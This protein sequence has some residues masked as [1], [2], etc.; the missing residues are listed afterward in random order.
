M[1]LLVDPN[2]VGNLPEGPVPKSLMILDWGKL[3][4][5]GNLIFFWI[6]RNGYNSY[7]STQRLPDYSYRVSR[8]APAPLLWRSISGYRV[9]IFID[10]IFLILSFFVTW[11]NSTYSIDM[12]IV[13]PGSKIKGPEPNKYYAPPYAAFRTRCPFYWLIDE[14]WLIFYLQLAIV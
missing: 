11:L 6:W 9:L 13:Y 10:T 7:F 8:R 14:C 4:S 5:I 3:P 2:S 12:V 1:I